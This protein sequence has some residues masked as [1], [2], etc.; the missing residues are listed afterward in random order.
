MC[1]YV[2][3][4][5][6]ICKII[7]TPISKRFQE[8]QVESPWQSPW[9]GPLFQVSSAISAIER[10][11]SPAPADPTCRGLHAWRKLAEAR[12]ILQPFGQEKW[13]TTVLWSYLLC[14]FSWSQSLERSVPKY[15]WKCSPHDLSGSHFPTI[16]TFVKAAQMRTNLKE[17]AL[18]YPWT[19]TSWNILNFIQLHHKSGAK[20]Q[21]H[22]HEGWLGS[23]SRLPTHDLRV[24]PFWMRT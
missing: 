24:L 14:H 20:T 3:V 21:I 16:P 5:I 8:I 2:Y 7:Y 15:S 10:F 9:K 6:Y 11:P 23:A 22:V 18:M 12:E 4:Y 19:Q 17:M 1:V 13:Y